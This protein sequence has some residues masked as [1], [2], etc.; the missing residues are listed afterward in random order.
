MRTGL[1]ISEVGRPGPRFLKG[2]AARMRRSDA[3]EV[4]GAAG[5][6]RAGLAA[7]LGREIEAAAR[8][9]GCTW[10]VMDGR[11][12]LALFGAVPDS[13]TARSARIW[14]LA[15]NEAQRR[16]LAF[17]RWSRRCLRLVMEAFPETES[18]YNCAPAADG[19]QRAWLEWLG[20][21]FSAQGRGSFVSPWTGDAFSMFVIQREDA[22]V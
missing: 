11:R 19:R 7:H 20:A 21:W 12:P 13:A 22:H 9:G 14:M 8:R 16:P 15:A 17:A 2:F 5:V 6:P 10:A 1:R 18:F 4:L 3:L